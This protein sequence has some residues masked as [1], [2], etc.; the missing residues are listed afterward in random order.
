[1]SLSFPEALTQATARTAN[2]AESY[3]TSGSA[4]LQLFSLGVSADFRQQVDLIKAALEE[5]LNLAVKII[6][7][8][9]DCR[10][11]QGHKDIIQVFYEVDPELLIKT[12]PAIATYGSYKDV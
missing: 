8:L 7:Y 4:C 12:I 10:G 6:Y 2:G 5:N 11:G 3:A 9:R 1:M